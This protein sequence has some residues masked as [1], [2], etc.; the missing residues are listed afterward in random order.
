MQSKQDREGRAFWAFMLLGTIVA[1]VLLSSAPARA[2]A[3][4][5]NAAPVRVGGK[6]FTEQLILSSMTSQYLRAKGLGTELTS[7]LGSTLM[8]QAME[9][10]QL[11][12]VWDYT[13]TALIVFNKVE[14]KLDAK[15]SY[16]RVKTLD[17]ARGLVWLEP[18]RIN[19]TYAL[20][21][22][23]QRAQASGV[24]TLS[25][26]AEKMRKA[27]EDAQHPFAVDMEFAA[28]PDG[29][30][31]FKAQYKLPFKR[32]DVIQ[33]DPGLVYTALKNNQVDM[34]LVYTTDGRVKGFELVLLED[35]LH[36]FPDYSAVPVVRKAVLDKHP[37]LATLLNALSAK[38]DNASMTEMN[39]QVDIGQQPV[40]KVAADFLRS[41]GLI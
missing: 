1:A 7:G 25:A 35:D 15:A 34:G 12:V 8:R 32:R 37:E 18:S 4:A 6:N 27:G 5:A 24:T 2:R 21:M 30:E 41:H 17:A 20:A 11:D 16:A 29:L 39:Y 22:P 3:P 38:L 9:N 14:E 26:Y 13:G 33:L 40:D 10:G 28:R 31:P 23:K 19:N 36:F